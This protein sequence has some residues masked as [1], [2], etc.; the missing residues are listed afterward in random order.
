MSANGPMD[1]TISAMTAPSANPGNQSGRDPA[2]SRSRPGPQRALFNNPVIAFSI[3][4]LT[5]TVR[6]LDDRGREQT[7]TQLTDDVLN[8]LAIK[9]TRRAKE[10][11]TQSIWLARRGARNQLSDVTAT[12]WQAGADEV[13]AWARAAR[14]DIDDQ[15]AI[16]G[17]V[18]AAYNHAH[19]DRPY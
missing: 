3:Q 11:I 1:A 10:I 7:V 15:D 13:R 6:R 18:T 9:P 5:D 2:A 19:P 12:A 4:E 17:E 14:Y 8:E 16:P